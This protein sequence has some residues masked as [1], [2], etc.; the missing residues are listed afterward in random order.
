MLLTTF[1]RLMCQRVDGSGGSCLALIGD[2]VTK[3]LIVHHADEDVN[4]HLLAEDARVHSLI[5]V[6]V[7]ALL[8]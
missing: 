1:N 3:A 5:A 4:L 8:E 7:V 6:V 2:H